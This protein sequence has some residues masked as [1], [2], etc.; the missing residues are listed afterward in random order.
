MKR[1]NRKLAAC[2]T[3]ALLTAGAAGVMPAVPVS[4]E[5]KTALYEGEAES[6]T[7]TA[8]GAVATKVYNDEYPGY[9]GE[10]FVWA[11]N[12]GGVSFEVELSEEG[13]CELR[14]RCRMYLGSTGDT[15]TQTVFADGEQVL[16]ADVPNMGDWYDFCFGSF[17]LPA[18][19]HTI[20]IGGAGS[21][22]FVLYDTVAFGYKKMPEHKIA[23]APCDKKATPETK[24]LMQYLTSV[25]G[26]QILSGQQ[27]IY[28]SGHDG[29]Y[30]YE[31]DYIKDATGKLP[32]IRG[33]DLM[34]YNPLYGWDDNTTERVI[35]WVTEKNGIATASCHWNIPKDFENY[36]LGDTVDWQ[37][38][39]YKD[40]ATSGST[41]NTANV[42]KK[43]TKERALFDEMVRM[44]AEQIQRMQDAGAPL[45]FRPLHEA[46]GNYGRYDGG[47]SAWFWWGDRGP[48]VYKE[49]WKLLYTELT[50]TYGLHNLLWEINIY[51]LENSMEWYPGDEYVDIIAYDKYEGSPTHWGKSS[52]ASVY[53][54]L[55]GDT[56][57]TKMVSIAECDSIP[58]IG[59][60][61]ND[62]AWWLYV[63]P[64]FD[65]YLTD[66]QYNPKDSLREFYTS[67]YVV[68]LD[69]LPADLYQN[70]Q[71]IPADTTV[72]AGGSTAQS[73]DAPALLPGDVD[74]NGAVQIA[75]AVLLARYLAEDK[76][77]NVT[78]EGK[79][80]AE[81][82]GTEG[83]N[84]D[85]LSCLL[86]MLAGTL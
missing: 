12:S 34:N 22:Y 55:V 70:G 6:C 36:T 31:F 44:A 79:L 26:R 21:Y 4:A 78:A 43:D 38:C 46:Q 7:V 73:S 75:D 1:N 41:F 60:M 2:L 39:S 53:F 65:T 30:E 84:A 68:T 20:E 58:A 57:D 51:E 8:G 19:K 63:C 3:A 80:N 54:K 66:A 27:E 61:K 16:S 14:S 82:D 71:I 64:W 52:A 48:E 15:R 86:R 77:L 83:L 49:L 24:A 25:Y 10:G 74:T 76:G 23:A 37:Q 62:G 50:E 40:C 47:G 56:D 5:I 85:D 13:M 42:L 32:A 81:L 72:S 18:G 67:D 69:E 59:N 9:S 35:D 28:G 29:N 45:I 33:F 17:Y 11:G